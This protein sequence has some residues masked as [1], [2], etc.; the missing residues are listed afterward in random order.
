[1]IRFGAYRSWWRPLPGWLKLVTVLGIYPAWFFIVYCVFTE[2]A[3]SREA[4]IAFCIFFIGTMLHI[5]FD[6]RNRGGTEESGGI[7]FFGGD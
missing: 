1:M 3:K 5:L 4:I 7:D 2:S 6:R